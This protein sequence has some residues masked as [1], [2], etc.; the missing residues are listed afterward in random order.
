[1]TAVSFDQGQYDN[2]RVHLTGSI[3]QVCF[4]AAD[5]EDFVFKVRDWRP[6]PADAFDHQSAYHVSLTDEARAEV[7]KWAWDQGA[8]LVE[9]HSHVGGVAAF[10]WS[11]VYGFDQWVPHVRWR[12]R[13][14]PYAAIVAAADTFDGFAW[15]DHSP[16]P[17]QLDK[18]RVGDRELEA[19]G[20]SLPRLGSLRREGRHAR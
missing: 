3:E 4:L 11:D 5:E 16:Q 18:L 20:I 10:S 9:A 14:A 19:T 15:F 6:M 13:G 17:V 12:M 7:I 2:L 1:M 8:C